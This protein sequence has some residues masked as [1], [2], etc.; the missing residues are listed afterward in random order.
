MG[1]LYTLPGV[2]GPQSAAV[3]DFNGDGKPD[4]AIGEYQQAPQVD[5]RL[6]N[7][8]GTFTF[9]S[10]VTLDSS[11][12]VVV[13]ADFNRDGKVDLA[14]LLGYSPNYSIRILLGNGDGTFTT[15]SKLPAI[16]DDDAL[17]VADFNGDGNLDLLVGGVSSPARLLLGNGDGT[18]QSPVGSVNWANYPGT[19]IAADFNHDGK[20]DVAGT[21]SNAAKLEVFLGN[22]DGTFQPAVSFPT[23]FAPIGLV[24]ADFNGDGKLDIAIATGEGINVFLG[25]G[26]GTFQSYTEYRSALVW[27]G[28]CDWIV[29]GDFNG[30]GKVDLATGDRQNGILYVYLGNG[31]GTFWTPLD[32]SVTPSLM[33]LATG[34][35]NRDGVTDLALGS[36]SAYPGTPS[37]FSVWSSAPFASIRPR[38]LDF[39]GVPGRQFKRAP[40]GQRVERRNS[41]SANRE[42]HGGW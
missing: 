7:D 31:D 4:L 18:F 36:G 21:I 30:D 9:G 26:D 12:L 3:A 25:N 29:A 41:T 6:G 16:F 38:S 42:S 22:G 34:D 40:N 8:D 39:G 20:M 19:L 33:V 13:Q 27:G 28:L 37:A 17:V 32:F 11:P 35:F 1:A 23:D 14:A 15:G 24:A 5:I 10:P 2:I